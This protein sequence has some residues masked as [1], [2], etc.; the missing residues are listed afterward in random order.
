MKKRIALLLALAIMV[1]GVLAACGGEKSQKTEGDPGENNVAVS[2]ADDEESDLSEDI[3]LAD[4]DGEWNSIAWYLDEEEVQEAYEELAE[5]QDISAEE[6]K[7]EYAKE[8]E[9][10]FMAM[11]IDGDEISFYEEPGGELIEASKY[12]YVKAHESEHGG[13]PF[14]WYEFEAEDDVEHKNILLLDVHGEETMP[15]FHAKYGENIDELVESLGWLPTL[16]SP[17]STMDQVYEE[18][19]D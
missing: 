1:T 11:K 19:A 9:T 17:T 10:D 3:E 16:I 2:P 15:H 12:N 7:E 18:I 6:A 4:W 13:Q 8:V 5:R 14:Y